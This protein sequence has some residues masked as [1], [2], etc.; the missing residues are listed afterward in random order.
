MSE[1]L[2]RAEFEKWGRDNF[3]NLSREGNRYKDDEVEDVWS[4]SELGW[5][6]RANA[7]DWDAVREAIA[8]FK[9][10]SAFERGQNKHERADWWD[11]LTYKLTAALPEN[12]K[13]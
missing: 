4:G 11:R 9:S 1:E 12:Q 3:V 7:G 2:C 10:N 8:N 5:N 13:P 6:T